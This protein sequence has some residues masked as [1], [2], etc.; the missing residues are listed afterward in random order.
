[1]EQ[2]KDT[3]WKVPT[4]ILCAYGVFFSLRPS[5][6]FLAPYL[7]GPYKNLTETEVY[8]QVY[9]VWTYAYLSF[10]IPVFIFTDYVKYKPIIVIQGMACV[11]VWLLLVFATGVPLMQLVEVL[12]GLVT[13]AEV[14]YYSYIYSVIH[15]DNYKQATSLIRAATRSGTFVAATFGQL[16]VSLADVDYFWLNV[17]SLV[18]VSIGFIITWFLPMPTTSLLFH[19]TDDHDENKYINGVRLQHDTDDDGSNM[20]IIDRPTTKKKSWRVVLKELL[21]DTRDC[22]SDMKLLKW[23]IWWSLS[24]NG[25]ILVANYS[26]LLW[27]NIYSSEDNTVYNGAVE[28]TAQLLGTVT[29]LSVGIIPIDW[30]R[31]GEVYLGVFSLVEGALLFLMYTTTNI[32]WNYVGYIGFNVSFYFVITISQY[33]IARQ[34]RSQ[35]FA[36]IF[37]LNTFLSL[38]LNTLITVIFIDGSGPV[39]LSIKESYLLFSCYFAGASVIFLTFAI[40][41]W[42]SVR[43]QCISNQLKVTAL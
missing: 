22:Y 19:N 38:I 41:S 11:C 28:C 7:L 43:K 4:Y 17:A 18:S 40:Y 36:L 29:T 25:W 31:W 26:Q 23:S 12:Y 14:A 24:T 2:L 30:S 37:G 32:W 34:L 27:E 8:S 9:P 1:M 5:E 16:L 21:R 33:E 15:P 42:W 20:Q 10:L 3:S 6:P 39:T 13:S 35:R